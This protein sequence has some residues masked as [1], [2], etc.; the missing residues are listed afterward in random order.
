MVGVWYFLP[1]AYMEHASVAQR[2]VAARDDRA[3][4]VRQARFL[5]WL[6][7]GWHGIEAAVA[8]GAGLA[9]GSVALVGFGADS[10]VEALAG[11][12][13]IWRFTGAR[14]F[15]ETAERRAQ[16]L[17]ASSFFLIAAYVGVEAIRN[18]VG[19][20]VPAT[21]WVGLGLALGDQE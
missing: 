17:I 8:V 7:V 2:G 6:G 4:W 21:R 20:E 19:R 11:F 15:S 12:I 16:W 5:A 18:L 10:V 14:Q 13:V 3:R 1:S 9:A